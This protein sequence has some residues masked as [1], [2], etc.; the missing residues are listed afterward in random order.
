MLH[1]RPGNRLRGKRGPAMLIAAGMLATLALMA[2]PPLADANFIYW[3]NGGQTSIGRAKINGTG[4]NN[5]FITTSGPVLGVA[6]DS[7][8]IY[9]TQGSGASSSI[10]RA[11]LDG[12]GANASFIPFS[13]GPDFGTPTAAIAV[14]PTGLYWANTVTGSIGH[15]NL[16][17]S[18]ADG[19]FINT[20]GS[21]VCGVAAD[22]N[23][24]YWLDGSIGQ[25]IGRAGLDGSNPNLGFISNTAANCGLA[26][27]SSYLYWGSNVQRGRACAGRRR[28]AEQSLHPERHPG[29]KP[30]LRCGGQPAV[31][32]LGQLRHIRLHRP[33]QSGWDCPESGLDQRS[34]RP[35]SDGGRP[36]EQDHGQLD[37]EEEEE[38]HGDHRRQGPWT[39]SGDAG[40]DEHPT[41]RQ[42]HSGWCQAGRPDDHAGI[43]VQS[44]GQAHRQDRKEAQEADQEAA[45]EEAQGE[46]QGEGQPSSSTSCR[47]A[48]RAC[49]T[50]SR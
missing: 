18:G 11:N 17:G 47:P 22:Q 37:R 48:W 6:V 12:S 40:S 13:A 38:G 44:P 20:A 31:C 2:L 36:L 10:G 5:G 14:A 41:R 26:V 49:R 27:D 4:A 29:R 32:L 24:V 19:H 50:P 45:P 16:D 42:C 28:H 23:F 21:S 39:G 35:M 3:A 46:G 8:Y 30:D 9:W 34:D 1:V 15:A 7:K 33:R 43:L 25:R